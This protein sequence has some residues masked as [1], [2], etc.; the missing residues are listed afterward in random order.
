MTVVNGV[1]LSFIDGIL[2]TLIVQVFGITMWLL[3]RA[4]NEKLNKS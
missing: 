3:I 1:M 2:L 4:V